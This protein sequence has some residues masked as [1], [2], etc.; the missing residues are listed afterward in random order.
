MK[1]I[2]AAIA[3]MSQA[4]I[5]ALER[6]DAF[7]F[8][9]DGEKID[10]TLSDVEIMSEDIVGWLVAN[11]GKLTVA[12]DIN[13]TDDLRNEGIAREFI[14]RIQNIRKDSGFEVTDKVD[15]EIQSNSDLNAAVEAF[16]DYISAQ[17]LAK[18][19]KIVEKTENGTPIDI[20]G[21]DV[22][23]SVKKITK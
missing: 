9:I 10:I 7:S 8:G 21:S 2:S 17:T 23:I 3:E 6:D 19:V 5:N 20:N 22:N 12:L 18:S 4:D 13:I 14:N 11:E 15:I 16:R 1:Q